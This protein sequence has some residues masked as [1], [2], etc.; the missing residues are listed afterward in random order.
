MN[1]DDAAKY[2]EVFSYIITILGVPAA[3]FVYVRERRKER[4]AKETETYYTMNDKY[5]EFLNLCREYAF[6]DIYDDKNS[7]FNRY[8]REEQRQALILFDMLLSIFE[9]AFVMYKDHKDD[10]R[11]DQ[12]EGWQTYM[13]CWMMRHD[14]RVCWADHLKSQWEVNFGKYMNHLYETQKPV[15]LDLSP[16]LTTGNL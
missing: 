3:I 10:F 5:F 6:L 16:A 13:K 14:F 11:K 9:R 8:S 2:L 1:L 4:M 15:L 12:W 7:D